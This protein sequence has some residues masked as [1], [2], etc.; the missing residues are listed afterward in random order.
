MKTKS[1]Y[2]IQAVENVNMCKV[3]EFQEFLTFSKINA[4]TRIKVQSKK[5]IDFKI[6]NMHHGLSLI[7]NPHTLTPFVKPQV[8]IVQK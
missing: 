1:T 6:Y 7:D 5:K 8:M 2:K 3:S 4:K